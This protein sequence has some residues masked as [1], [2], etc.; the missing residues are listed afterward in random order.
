MIYLAKRDTLEPRRGA[1]LKGS[2]PHTQ[3]PGLQETLFESIPNSACLSSPV[4]SGLG[5]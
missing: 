1:D 5:R 4:E 2:G 3:V